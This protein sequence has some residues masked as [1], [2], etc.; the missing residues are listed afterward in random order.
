[1]IKKN[2]LYPKNIAIS[3]YQVEFL[4]ATL[5]TLTLL[6]RFLSLIKYLLWVFQK[7]PCL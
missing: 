4:K 3:I 6:L 1:M 7:K 5:H 2:L